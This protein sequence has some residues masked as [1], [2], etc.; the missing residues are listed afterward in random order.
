MIRDEQLIAT[1]AAELGVR[2]VVC[3]N[4]ADL[5]DDIERSNMKQYD[6]YNDFGDCL[7]QVWG[8]D[9]ADAL[10]TAQEEYGGYVYV[11]PAAKVSE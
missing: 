6:V 4:G 11:V 10:T 3:G 1:I 9:A 8:S 2:A 5:L 7:G